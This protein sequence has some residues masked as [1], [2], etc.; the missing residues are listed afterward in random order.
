[1]QES[2]VPDERKDFV[3]PKVGY[4]VYRNC[5]IGGAPYLPGPGGLLCLPIGAV[6]EA[7]TGFPLLHSLFFWFIMGSEYI[8]GVS[9]GG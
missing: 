5:T 2:A 9:D 8:N 1:M 7:E 6:R 3:V 4:A